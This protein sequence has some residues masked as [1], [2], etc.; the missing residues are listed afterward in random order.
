MLTTKK[1]IIMHFFS[2]AAAL[3]VMAA[4]AVSAEKTMQINNYSDST[5]HNF[6]GQVEVTWAHVSVQWQGQLLQLPIWQQ[7]QH[8]SRQQAWRLPLQLLLSAQLPG[9]RHSA[10][11]AQRKLHR[12]CTAAQVLCLLPPIN[13]VIGSIAASCIYLTLSLHGSGCLR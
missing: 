5:C 12:W 11:P 6:Q 2:A 4:T 7:C 13:S 9:W 8:C 1:V 3:A 10:S